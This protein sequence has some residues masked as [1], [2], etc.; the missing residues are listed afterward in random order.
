MEM[1][2]SPDTRKFLDL[3]TR[4]AEDLAGWIALAREHHGLS[5]DQLTTLL[6]AS[7][8]IDKTATRVAG[9]S[10]AG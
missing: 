8:V 1:T 6:A 3:S 7:E 9:V 5:A 10:E 2:N 4:L